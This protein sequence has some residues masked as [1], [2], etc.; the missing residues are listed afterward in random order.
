MITTAEEIEIETYREC[1]LCCDIINK[2]DKS[3]YFWDGERLVN[4]CRNCAERL[5]G[6][7]ERIIGIV[8][9]RE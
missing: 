1:A 9:C 7:G 6:K 4:V 3:V 2:N 5:L 8:N